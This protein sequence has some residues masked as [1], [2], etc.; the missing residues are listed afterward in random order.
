VIADQFR[1]EFGNEPTVIARAPG[2]VNLIGEH[3]DYTG[4]AVMPMAIDREVLVAARRADGPH[5]LRSEARPNST[6]WHRYVLAA[7]AESYSDGGV[8]ILVG[9][10]LPSTGGLSS[11]SALTVATLLASDALAGRQ[12]SADGEVARAVRAERSIGAEGGT[13]DQTVIVHAAAGSAL[14]IDFVPPRMRTIPLPP[15]LAVVVAYSGTPAAKG[16]A[17]RDAYNSRVVTSR[18]VALL[19]GHQH[20]L[21]PGDPP[22]VGLVV[23]AVGSSSFPQSATASEVASAVGCDADHLVTLASGRFDPDRPLA[24]SESARHLTE[25]AS[26]VDAMEVAL[27]TGDLVQAGRILDASH[28]SLHRFGASTAG[29]DRVT[30]AMRAAGAFGSRLTGAGFGGFAMAF[31][32]AE[33]TAA[34][35]AAGGEGDGGL[36]FAV[37]PAAGAEILR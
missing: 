2:R 34:V 7:L 26:R 13:M 6:E 35:V 3:T 4:L 27:G 24:V 8:E 22:L 16:G 1:A 11:S 18:A 17:A 37:E 28:A 31:C 21:E 30:A 12:D 14:R 19:T 29:L 20:G 15:G 33:A 36:A 9:G 5:D 32:P 25:E 10:D 23:D